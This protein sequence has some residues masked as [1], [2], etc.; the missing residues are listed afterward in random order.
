MIIARSDRLIATI[1]NPPPTGSIADNGGTLVLR[2]QYLRYLR[3][4][5]PYVNAIQAGAITVI[6]ARSDR[7][8]ATIANLPPTNS[9]AGN[10]Y[11]LMPRRR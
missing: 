10:G 9:I 3:W 6:I 1:T 8:R 2:R 5:E 4:R 11:T 7:L